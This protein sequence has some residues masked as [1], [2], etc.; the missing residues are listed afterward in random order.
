MNNMARNVEVVYENGV[1][2][3][4]EI[5][6]YPEHERLTIIVPEQDD[7]PWRR[8]SIASFFRRPQRIYSR[9]DR[10]QRWTRCRQ[11][12]PDCLGVSALT[13]SPGARIAYN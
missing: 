9:S 11:S 2:R 6:Q 13:S 4:L 10:S 1:L 8:L 12:S 7:D 3:P 5:L